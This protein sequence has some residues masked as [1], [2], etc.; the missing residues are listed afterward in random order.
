[1]GSG[2][3]AVKDHWWIGVL[4]ALIPVWQT[5]Y[6]S[7]S[8][9]IR[10]RTDEQWRTESRQSWKNKFDSIYVRIDS[11]TKRMGSHEIADSAYEANHH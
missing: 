9:N 2:K 4:V 3:Q 10:N 11:L 6:S 5:L 7:H 8:D 1:M